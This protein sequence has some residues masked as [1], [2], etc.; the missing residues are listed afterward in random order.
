MCWGAGG[1]V[2]GSAG[3]EHVLQKVLLGVGRPVDMFSSGIISISRFCLWCLVK[4]D[5]QIAILAFVG[6]YWCGPKS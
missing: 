1:A 3:D 2:L 4:N 5:L 6:S